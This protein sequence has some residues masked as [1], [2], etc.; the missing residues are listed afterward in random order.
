MIMTEQELEQALIGK[1]TDLKYTHRPEIRDRAA[2][3]GN[4]RIHFEALN[5]V[6]LTDG[7][8]KRL[9]GMGT[10]LRC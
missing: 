5:R 3:E 8:F 7:E 1:L 10:P 4:F 6:N 2:L 9:L